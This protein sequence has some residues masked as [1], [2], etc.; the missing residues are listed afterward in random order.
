MPFLH[1][2][3]DNFN[4]LPEKGEIQGFHGKKFSFL[5]IL[6]LLNKDKYTFSLSLF[7]KYKDF[8]YLYK[9]K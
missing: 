7:Y 1:S 8:L 5:F 6:S 9:I 2:G 4:E 3:H